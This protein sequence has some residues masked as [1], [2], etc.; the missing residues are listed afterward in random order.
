M[1]IVG[2][3][4]TNTAEQNSKNGMEIYHVIVAYTVLFYI[5]YHYNIVI[6]VIYSS[7]I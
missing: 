6:S 3:A 7:S 4:I 5:I 2:T 1:G